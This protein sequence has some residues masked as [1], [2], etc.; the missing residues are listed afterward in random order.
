MLSKYVGHEWIQLPKTLHGQQL[1]HYTNLQ[2]KYIEACMEKNYKKE[3]NACKVLN[4]LFL[5][6]MM[7]LF[8]TLCILLLIKKMGSHINRTKTLFSP[9]QLHTDL[10]SPHRHLSLCN[11]LTIDTYYVSQPS[12]LATKWFHKSH[13]MNIEGLTAFSLQQMRFTPNTSWTGTATLWKAWC[14]LSPMHN[15]TRLR[16]VFQDTQHKYIQNS[17]LFPTIIWDRSQTSWLSRTTR[18][19]ER[20]NSEERPTVNYKS[21]H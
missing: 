12:L 19:A 18:Q 3:L 7:V 4:S 1:Q 15:N 10:S 9:S 11:W 8:M 16:T 2:S 14:I 6:F 13:K 17:N 20:T 5:F 21:R